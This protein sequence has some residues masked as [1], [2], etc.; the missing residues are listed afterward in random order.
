MTGLY[1]STSG[2]YLQLQDQNIKKGNALVAKST[3]MP[4][5]FEKHG[6]KTFGVGK[7]Y[8]GGDMA[9]TFDEF[10]GWFS[11]FGPKPPERMKYDPSKMPD[12]TGGT[13]T[14]WGPY[15]KH[16]SAMTDYKVAE[17]AI[18]KLNETH[19]EPFFLA[20]GFLRPHVPWH[21]PQKWFDMFPLEEIQLPPYLKNDLDDVPEMGRKV[22]EAPQMP[23]AEGLMERGEWKEVIQAYLACLHLLIPRLEKFWMRLKL[24]IML[25]IP[26]SY[27]GRIMVIT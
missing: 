8:H 17:Y 12:K 14:D 25:I 22:N 20:A 24:Q 3:F 26:S 13:Q 1:P 21:V 5:Y 15:P 6:Y 16:D 7:I 27:Y 11:W 10:G 9:G 18:G 23:T 19:D 4:D 2:N